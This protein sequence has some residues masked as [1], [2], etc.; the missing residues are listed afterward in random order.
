MTELLLEFRYNGTRKLLQ[1][2]ELTLTRCIDICRSNKAT[3]FKL[4]AMSNQEDHKFFLDGKSKGKTSENMNDKGLS[5]VI[6]CKFC[7]KWH[8]KKTRRLP[9]MRRELY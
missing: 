2:Q 3:T 8:T 4:Q 5:T 6:A 1:E 7:G 9:C